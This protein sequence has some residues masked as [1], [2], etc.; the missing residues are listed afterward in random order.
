M[1]ASYWDAV[2]NPEKNPLSGLPKTYRFQVMTV[3]ALMWTTVFCASAGLFM[4]FPEFVA[5][6]FVLLLMGIFGTSYI[7]RL[8]RD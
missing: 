4:W 1:I 6:H 3:L 7:F 8:H 2:M 5:A